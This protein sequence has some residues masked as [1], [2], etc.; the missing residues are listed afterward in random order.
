MD[1]FLAYADHYL[2]EFL[3]EHV[4][5]WSMEALFHRIQDDLPLTLFDVY[6]PDFFSH[7]LII[8]QFCNQHPTNTAELMFEYIEIRTF[9]LKST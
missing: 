3:A 6:H 5:S 4:P 8:E 2:D 7:Y 1:T 9:N